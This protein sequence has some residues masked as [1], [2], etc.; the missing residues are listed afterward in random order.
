MHVWDETKTA[1]VTNLTFGMLRS[2]SAVLILISGLCRVAGSTETV[3]VVRFNMSEASVLA[4]IGSE[5]TMCLYDI[6]TGKA[7]RRIVMQAS[8]LLRP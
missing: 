6:R 7:E 5:R 8:S 1:P 4:S 2:F 3:D